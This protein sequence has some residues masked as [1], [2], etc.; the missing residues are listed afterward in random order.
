MYNTKSIVKY[1]DIKNELLVKL[2]NK[3]EITNKSDEDDYDYDENDYDY[4]E[5]DID[6]ICEKLYREEFLAVFGVE[7]FMDDKIDEQMVELK[8]L[9]FEN[10]KIKKM[11]DECI[12][13]HSS[14]KK[15]ESSSDKEKQDEAS[16]F[17]NAIFFSMFGY[18]MFYATHQIICQ[19]METEDFNESLLDDIIKQVI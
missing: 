10:D 19:L 15:D 11:I 5:N 9:L 16:M 1:N 7:D 6:L 2:K 8:E 14:A 3:S 12:N 18:K 4:D 13:T 17:K